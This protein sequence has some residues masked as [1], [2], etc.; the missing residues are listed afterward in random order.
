[1]APVSRQQR[2]VSLAPYPK[3]TGLDWVTPHTFPNTVATLISE[4]DSETASQL[5]GH[6]SP[7]SPES[8]MSEPAIAADVAR[9]L[10]KQGRPEPD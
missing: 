2:R 3:D 6:F 9:V 8:Y 10:E 5:L 1:M 7:R 4:R